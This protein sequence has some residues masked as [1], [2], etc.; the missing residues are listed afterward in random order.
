[1]PIYFFLI[2][3]HMHR[4][5]YFPIYPSTRRFSCLSTYQAIYTFI[6]ISVYLC[7]YLPH[8]QKYFHCVFSPH[9][10][11]LYPYNF[12]GF[13][14]SCMYS[15]YRTETVNETAE[16][17]LNGTLDLLP[18]SSSSANGSSYRASL[19]ASSYS[20]PT[21]MVISPSPITTQPTQRSLYANSLME[22]IVNQTS[23]TAAA[24]NYGAGGAPSKAGA[25]SAANCTRTVQK[26]VYAGGQ[27]VENERIFPFWFMDLYQKIFISFYIISLLSVFLLYFFI[28][29][30][31]AQRRKW[32]RR[33]KSCSH[34]PMTQM[35][36]ANHGGQH[37]DVGVT[38]DKV[39]A[40]NNRGSVRSAMNN[41]SGQAAAES[42]SLKPWSHSGSPAGVAASHSAPN[43]SGVTN[44][45][46]SSTE[47]GD[48]QAPGVETAASDPQANSNGKSEGSERGD[49]NRSPEDKSTDNEITPVA[50]AGSNESPTTSIGG[51]GVAKN[52]KKKKKPATAS[53]DQ[54]TFQGDVA[55]VEKAS[56]SGGHENGVGKRLTLAIP[57]AQTTAAEKKTS[58]ERRDF[59]FLAN[60]RT[61]MM[62][63]VVTLVFTACFMPA[64]LMASQLLTFQPIVFYSHFLYNVANPVIYAFM[65]Q[66]F[67]K[68]LK[69]V[70]QRGTHLFRS[71]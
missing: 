50:A 65:N 30:S 22:I 21:S 42:Y 71:W 46:T 3:L 69:R 57:S 5:I 36:N 41:G 7:I 14:T 25:M 56:E 54:V 34:S 32:R 60:I 28:Y 6:Y 70:F 43:I 53:G 58:R 24:P 35:S 15:T 18:L 33:Q 67:R 49:E 2:C 29:R 62:L 61:A 26:M 48:E 8:V 1:M 23:A 37:E 20:T 4:F 38:P 12:P 47:L 59:N 68:E 64:W 10:L 17:C 51:D 13:I 44:A 16:W 27:C 66:S 63:F 9:P 19:F 52:Q 31:V 45:T 40:L 39:A 55:D 11:P